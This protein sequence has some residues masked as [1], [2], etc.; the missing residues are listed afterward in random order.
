MRTLVLYHA[1]CWD[2]LVAAWSLGLDPATTTYIEYDHGKPLVADVAFHRV[3]A[4]PAHTVTRII[5]VDCF[6]EFIRGSAPEVIVL[7]HHESAQ[8][9]LQDRTG[10]TEVVFDM[11]HS[12]ADLAWRWAHPDQPVPVLNLYVEDRDL[13]KW[14]M[15]HSREVSAYISTLPMTFEAVTRTRS[16]IGAGHI[17]DII[18]KG[19][20]ILDYQA[21][22]VQSVVKRAQ[23]RI[24]D[25]VRCAVVNA[26]TLVSEAG[27]AL[28]DGTDTPV[29]LL[30]RIDGDTLN[31]SVRTAKDSPIKANDFAARF[32]G[33]GH[34]QAAGF[35]LP[36]TSG[37]AGLFAGVV[38]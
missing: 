13:W 36:L 14:K 15:S 28:V 34:P 22:V 21:Q 6:P 20:A 5:A 24:I 37:P 38:A 11:T 16:E 8:E 3:L 33:G 9:R 7:D 29:A 2:G 1:P 10:L 35:H 32:G 19:R 17:D 12:A 4:N 23:V 27:H 26:T 31:V 18:G 25:G 30:Y